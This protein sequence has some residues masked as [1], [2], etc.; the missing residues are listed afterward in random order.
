MTKRNEASKK[1][2]N[3]YVNN[4]ISEFHNTGK[5]QTIPLARQYRCTEVPPNRFKLMRL[6]GINRQLNMGE[7][8]IIYQHVRNPM[9]LQE[10]E[11]VG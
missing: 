11:L 6:G 5:I 4:L 8:E 10:G 9:W 1:A 7:T 3:D 2:F